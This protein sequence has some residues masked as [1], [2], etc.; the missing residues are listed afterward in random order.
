LQV[1]HLPAQDVHEGAE[2]EVSVHAKQ[3]VALFTQDVHLESQIAQFE[4]TVS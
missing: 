1:L 4:D 2:R 3:L